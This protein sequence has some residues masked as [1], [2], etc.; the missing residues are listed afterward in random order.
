M[1]IVTC[2]RNTLPRV[3]YRCNDDA[4]CEQRNGEGRCN[5]NQGFVGDGVTCPRHLRYVQGID[6]MLSVI[7]YVDYMDEC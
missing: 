3:S 2:S 4:T 5:C 1:S 6:R 7:L